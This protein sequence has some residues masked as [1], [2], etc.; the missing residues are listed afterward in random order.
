MRH[1]LFTCSFALFANGAS[2]LAQAPTPLTPQ[3]SKSV[4]LSGEQTTVNLILRRSETPHTL[5]G[6]YSVGKG[7]TLILEAGANIRCDSGSSL[8]INKDA[9]LL[10]VG[11]AAEPIIFFGKKELPNFWQGLLISESK[12][13]SLRQVHV[14]DAETGVTVKSCDFSAEECVFA[15]CGQGLTAINH[16]KKTELKECCL[17]YNLGDGAMMHYCNVEFKYCSFTHNEKLG[18][19]CNYYASPILRNC[20]IRW[21]SEGGIHLNLYENT[22]SAH[23][24]I[25]L[26]NTDR[27]A[28]KAREEGR[29]EVKNTSGSELDFTGNYW[30]KKLASN[31]NETNL[32]YIWDSLDNPE[33]GKVNIAKALDSE[34]ES[35][36][37]TRAKTRNKKIK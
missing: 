10:C 11:T 33:C 4:S 7:Q 6:D 31:K 21:N 34:P 18:V 16:D 29:F 15:F 1:L 37:A 8:S 25:F 23:G 28:K 19:R 35:C 12:E 32:I 3:I 26:D 27:L 13:A 2:C 20:L 5:S 14:F 24:C 9:R 30:G 22:G 36:G 17:S